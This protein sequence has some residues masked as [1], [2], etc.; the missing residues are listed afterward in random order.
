LAPDAHKLTRY[1][2]PEHRTAAKRA[3]EADQGHQ[4][5]GAGVRHAPQTVAGNGVSVECAIG[6]REAPPPVADG[7]AILALELLGSPAVGDVELQTPGGWRLV[8]HRT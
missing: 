8:A 4:D 5:L 3:R 6:T 2:S 1:C 7:L